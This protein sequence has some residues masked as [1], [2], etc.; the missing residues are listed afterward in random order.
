MNRTVTAY[1]LSRVLAPI[2][3]QVTGTAMTLR[4]RLKVVY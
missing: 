2:A 4:F 1:A 3:R